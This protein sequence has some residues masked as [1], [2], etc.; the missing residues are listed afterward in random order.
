MIQYLLLVLSALAIVSCSSPK[1]L[2]VVESVDLD[3]YKGR[4]YEWARFDHSFEKGC[5]CS[6]AEYTIEDDYVGVTNYCLEDGEWRSTDG[7]AFPVEGA[8][9]AKLEVQF[10]WP[11]RGDYYI[12]ALDD[13]YQHALVGAPNRDYLWILARSTKVDTTVL[14]ELKAKASSLG[15]DVS[16]LLMTTCD[17]APPLTP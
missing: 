12:I 6:V 17:S 8:K 14:N 15:F 10:F 16:R 9:N 3:K 5:D 2:P 13:E 4:W 1:P 7:K 11:F